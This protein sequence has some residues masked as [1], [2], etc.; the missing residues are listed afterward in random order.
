MPRRTA[1]SGN[2]ATCSPAGSGLAVSTDDDR[3]AYRRCLLQHHVDL[4]SVQDAA[5]TS[6]AL[7]RM[8]RFPETY[9]IDKNGM[10][11]QMYIGPQGFTS[12]RIMDPVK[13]LTTEQEPMTPYGDPNP[14]RQFGETLHGKGC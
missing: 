2:H 9:V 14:D 4:L 5:Q 10:V 3:G 8:Y 7:Y 11:R 12:S 13:Q 1:K 6:N